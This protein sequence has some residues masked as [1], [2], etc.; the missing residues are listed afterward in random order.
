V[1]ET[2]LTQQQGRVLTPHYASPEQVAGDAI[3][4]QSD[5]YS[6][7]VLL[8]ELLTSTLPIAPRRSTLGAVEEAILQGDAPPASSRVKDKATARALRGEVDAI[9]GKAMQRAPARRYATADAMAQDIER[10]LNGETVA[11]RPDSLVYRLRKGLRRN[12]VGVTAVTAVLVAVLTGSGVAV[13]QAQRAARSAERER[14]VKDFVADVF[15]MNVGAGVHSPADSS[16]SPKALLDGGAKLIQRRFSGQ[17]ELQAELYAVVGEVFSDMGAH[18]TAADYATHRVEALTALKSDELEQSR[19]LLQLALSQ[20]KDRRFA[21][22]ELRVRRALEISAADRRMRLD[23]LVLLA[24]IQDRASHHEALKNTLR[25][26]EQLSSAN[27]PADAMARAWALAIHAAENM[28]DNRFDLGVEQL[29]SAIEL[30]LQTEGPTSLAAVDMRLRLGWSRTEWGSEDKGRAIYGAALSTLRSLGGAHAIRAAKEWASFEGQMYLT[31]GTARAGPA[32]SALSSALA[33]M[34]ASSLPIPDWYISD[35]QFAIGAV[36]VDA[37][38]IEAGLPLLQQAAPK[39][40]AALGATRPFSVSYHLGVALSNAGY[41]QPAHRYFKETVEIRRAEGM[42]AHPYAA[43]DYMDVAKNLA[44]AGRIQEAEAVYDSMPTFDLLKLGEV[45]PK[46][47]QRQLVYERAQA[48]LAA[49]DAAAALALLKGN[50]PPPLTAGFEWHARSFNKQAGE[51][52]CASNRKR[53]GLELL[54]GLI[55]HE[56]QLDGS[57]YA[58][59]LARL[60]ALAGLCSL[61]LGNRVSALNYAGGARAAFT[62]QPGVSA[63]Y[64]APLRQLERAL[65]LKAPP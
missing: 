7:G 22:A 13:V 35:I 57:P 2:G 45:D 50:E 3:T 18:R 62:A 31:S 63:Y 48:K 29:E 44:M 51:A 28:R 8:Y 19:A 54:Q 15:R 12:W 24:R 41:H 56:E 17:P 40:L 49:G 53:E 23:A 4:V 36:L 9:L 52:Y 6:L 37:G 47:Y 30:A 25:D 64:K 26:I 58:P 55:A 21:D 60:K 14:V 1:P 65:G 42:G 20:F 16:G 10:H 59:N 34:Q 61:G 43:T 39:L 27:D 33:E 11:A 5:V 46:L 38:Y 32:L